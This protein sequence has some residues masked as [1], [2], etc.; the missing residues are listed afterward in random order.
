MK[1]TELGKDII[2]IDESFD[3]NEHVEHKVHL[4][5]LKFKTPSFEIMDGITN[6]FHKT[7]RYIIDSSNIRLY[8][9][10]FKKTSLKYY[11]INTD[12]N[13][14]GIVSFFKR[15]NKVIL[16][17]NQLNDIDKE[18]LFIDEVLCDILSNTEV[19]VISKDDYTKRLDIFDR[20]NGNCIITDKPL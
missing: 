18:Y 12:G 19:V 17:F 8:N 9:A 1:T 10:Y 6:T 20:W 15:N 13:Y 2:I 5:C 14:T 7:N 4:I 3:L 11:V 16:D